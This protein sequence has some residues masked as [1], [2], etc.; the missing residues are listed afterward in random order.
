MDQKALSISVD[1]ILS[2]EREKPEGRDSRGDGDD[3][4]VASHQLGRET[5]TSTHHFHPFTMA[6]QA[7]DHELLDGDLDY[8]FG[9]DE[10]RSFAE[11]VDLVAD[12]HG[13][14][15]GGDP[16]IKVLH[17]VLNTVTAPRRTLL[18]E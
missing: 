7:A 16:A 9:L 8:D 15:S 1:E 12:G 10:D 5:E 18:G 17:A 13:I 4:Q 6:L 14:G 2:S 3:E 11:Q